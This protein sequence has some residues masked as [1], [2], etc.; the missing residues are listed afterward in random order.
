MSVSGSFVW[1][2]KIFTVFVCCAQIKALLQKFIGSISIA[3]NDNMKRIDFQNSAYL[4]YL[5]TA[6]IGSGA[7]GGEPHYFSALSVIF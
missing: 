5:Q 7:Q 4:R 1:S 2:K 3:Y 6:D